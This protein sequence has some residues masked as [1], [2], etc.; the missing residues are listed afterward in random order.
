M[1]ARAM[2]W[3]FCLLQTMAR[4]FSDLAFGQA[5]T[6][7]QARKAKCTAWMAQCADKATQAKE[8]MDVQGMLKE[9]L[10]RFEEGCFWTPEGAPL[11]RE[12]QRL[13]TTVRYFVQDTRRS[14]EETLAPSVPFEQVQSAHR[15]L[16]TSLR[17][18]SHVA[19][20]NLLA[21]LP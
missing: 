11:A 17:E 5:L 15:R 1:D 6:A 7:W 16:V 13:L 14:L 21:I 19:A 10:E 12:V 3:T 20:P 8:E 4:Y 18:S 2:W 9:T